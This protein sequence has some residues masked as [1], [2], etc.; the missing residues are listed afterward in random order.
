PQQRPARHYPRLRL[1]TPLG[2]GPT[3]PFTSKFSAPPGAH[4]DVLRQSASGSSAAEEAFRLS[5]HMRTDWLSFATTGDPGWAPY[6][7]NTRSTR[8]YDAAPTTLPYPEET[9]RRIWHQHQFD[10]LDLLKGEEVMEL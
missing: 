6:D 3:G 10:T 5:Q 2:A 4:D 7:A 8:V 9:S 1:R